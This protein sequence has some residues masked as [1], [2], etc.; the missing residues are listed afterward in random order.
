[1][2][3][4]S[5]AYRKIVSDWVFIFTYLKNFSEWVFRIPVFLLGSLVFIFLLYLVLF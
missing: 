1:M 5:V 2:V 3:N 4:E